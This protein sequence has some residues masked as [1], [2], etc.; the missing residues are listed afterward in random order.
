M[1]TKP[2]AP[3]RTLWLL[4][5]AKTVTDPPPG[6]DDFDRILA[7][8]GRRDAEALGHL[9]A[10]AG[11][12]LGPALQRTPRPRVALVS[13]AARTAATAVLVLAHVAD[14]PEVRH[15][16][17]LYGADPE[18]VLTFVRDLP[19]D[20][21]AAMVVGHNPTAHALSQGLL[22]ARDKKGLSIAVR[23]GFPTCALG[24]Y[25]FNVGRWADVAARSGKL[26][27]LLAPPYSLQAAG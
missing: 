9:F 1:A 21:D 18:Q 12:G 27:A 19:D 24:V 14:P 3:G 25:S 8:R 7:P 11:E 23:N 5:H 13:P 26:V 20:I 4:R 16:E 22:S 2:K 15:E 6:G 10:G 17:G